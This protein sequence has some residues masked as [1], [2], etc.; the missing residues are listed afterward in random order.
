M[1]SRNSHY[2]FSACLEYHN[3]DGKAKIC[4][5]SDNFYIYICRKICTNIDYIGFLYCIYLSILSDGKL[6][7]LNIYSQVANIYTI[8]SN[9]RV[10]C[11]LP[12][13]IYMSPVLF[14]Q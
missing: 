1:G 12:H 4:K 8:C 9:C 10:L 11:I 2:F 3:Y 7:C 5:I 14:S 6:N 13:S